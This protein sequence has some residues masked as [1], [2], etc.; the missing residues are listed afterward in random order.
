MQFGGKDN[1]F[2]S[3]LQTIPT[4]YSTKLHPYNFPRRFP[5]DSPLF[6]LNPVSFWTGRGEKLEGRKFVCNFAAFSK[7]GDAVFGFV[8]LPQ[9]RRCCRLSVTSL[10]RLS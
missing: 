6:P 2:I 7:M 9:K 10:A 4:F 3:F 8:G 1:H 5:R